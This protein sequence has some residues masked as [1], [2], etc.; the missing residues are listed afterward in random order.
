MDYQEAEGWQSKQRCLHEES[1]H[2]A[3][4]V[5]KVSPPEL[6]CA[7]PLPRQ[8]GEKRA[9]T[10]AHPCPTGGAW[11]SKLAP[12]CLCLPTFTEPELLF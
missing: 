6:S 11:S 10:A 5:Q 9:L 2:P 8:Q 7:V 12:R 1:S 3:E 4:T